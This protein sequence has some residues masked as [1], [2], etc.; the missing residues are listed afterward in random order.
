[1]AIGTYRA[2]VLDGINGVRFSD[3][4]ERDQMVHVNEILRE[5]SNEGAGS[6]PSCAQRVASRAGSMSENA[7]QHEPPRHHRNPIGRVA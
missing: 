3:S 7:R 4:C 5:T 1:M 2:K 6:F